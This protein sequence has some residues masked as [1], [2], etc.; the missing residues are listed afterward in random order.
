MVTDQST[1]EGFPLSLAASPA[2][3]PRIETAGRKKKKKNQDLKRFGEMP[4]ST[5]T[6]NKTEALFLLKA[7][8]SA[9]LNGL[10]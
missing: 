2:A 9:I 5:V 10:L 7:D 1:L 8:V 4:C 3:A 6:G